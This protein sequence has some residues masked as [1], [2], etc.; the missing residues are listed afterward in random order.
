MV[1]TVSNAGVKQVACT[2]DTGSAL[3]S[4]A[5]DEYAL[6]LLR[7]EVIHLLTYH[8]DLF[9]VCRCKVLP[10]E[11]EVGNAAVVEHFGVIAEPDA[12]VNAVSA[13]RVLTW[14]L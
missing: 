1:R 13:R 7:R 14:L 5:V 11:V 12:V 10:V 6:A 3:A 8:Q 4:V 2:D 9:W